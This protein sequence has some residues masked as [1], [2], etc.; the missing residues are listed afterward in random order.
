MLSDS[1]LYRHVL[2]VL[3]F[4]PLPPAGPHRSWLILTTLPGAR[5]CCLMT[6]LRRQL[7]GW[8]HGIL[9]GRTLIIILTGKQWSENGGFRVIFPPKNP[10]VTGTGGFSTG[11]PSVVRQMFYPSNILKPYK[12]PQL[13]VGISRDLHPFTN[14]LRCQLQFEG[15]ITVWE[16]CIIVQMPCFSPSNHRVSVEPASLGKCH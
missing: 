13:Q 14:R 9:L 5:L 2:L 15:P 10:C 11:A 3:N 1:Y 7:T 16:K 12:S 4:P 8:R 6:T